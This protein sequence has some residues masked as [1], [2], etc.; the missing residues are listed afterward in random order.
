MRAGAVTIAAVAFLG[1]AYA[2]A[3]EP[4]LQRVGYYPQ[5]FVADRHGKV[6]RLTHG[7]H[8]HGSPT[9]A[10]GGHSL[11]IFNDGDIEIIAASGGRVIERL[12]G[13]PLGSSNVAWSPDGRRLALARYFGGRNG[14]LT[15]ASPDGGHGRDIAHR[16]GGRVEW[17]PDGRTIYYLH[18][19]EPEPDAALKPRDLYAIPSA[20]GARRRI[21]ANVE[22][23]GGVSPDGRW[24]VFT[25]RPARWFP[26]G[27]PLWIART[28]GSMERLLG[29]RL[30][31]YRFGW[32]PGH[33]G[34][35]VVQYRNLHGHPVV[36]ST[37]GK[38]RRLG[39]KVGI[40]A[41]AWSPDGRWMASSRESGGPSRVVT[42]R[43]DGSD[44]RVAARFSAPPFVELRYLA[45]APGGNRLAI[46]A[47]RHDGD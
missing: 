20:G 14:H 38:V 44:R 8:S 10:P 32:A 39:A 7:H 30:N 29:D 26:Y 6:H 23:F 15:V 24:V 36:V 25:R 33:R 45:W 13:G 4:E 1:A 11:A 21:A 5:I 16:A 2:F 31:V 28:D 40:Y 35:W 3:R 18:G 43:P 17:S 27:P 22:E 37:H 34:V 46:V 42:S 41:F 9:W 12:D 47:Y 19:R